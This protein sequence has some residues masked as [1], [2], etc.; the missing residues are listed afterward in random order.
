[1]RDSPL[2]TV[3]SIDVPLQKPGDLGISQMKY[4]IKDGRSKVA[5]NPFESMQ[6]YTQRFSK[7]KRTMP[8]LDS[9]QYGS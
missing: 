9:R 4:P 6:T 7:P 8:Q 1:M 2:Y 3:L 5:S